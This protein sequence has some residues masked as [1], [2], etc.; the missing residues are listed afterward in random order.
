MAINKDNES[1]KEIGDIS[2]VAQVV[3]SGIMLLIHKFFPKNNFTLVDPPV[4]HEKIPHKKHEIYLTVHEDQY[5]LNSSNALYMTAYSSVFGCVYAISPAFRDEQDSVNHLMEFRILEVEIQDM[6]YN[7]LPDFIE[8]FILFVVTGLETLPEMQKFPEVLKRIKGI[9]DNFPFRR[10]SYRSFLD[11]LWNHG[12]PIKDEI[13]LSDVDYMISQYID[14][15]VFII[16]YPKHLATWT[17]KVKH[18]TDMCAINLIL[19][20]SYGELCEGCE[21]TNDTALLRYKIQCANIDNLQWYLD[22]V[23]EIHK[24]RCGF[25]IGIERLVRWII[26][27]P[28]IK[29]TMFFPRT[30]P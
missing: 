29:D 11:E 10:I 1:F 9:R 14:A 8:R 16:D 2:V 20:G 4:L 13:D 18:D 24:S 19:P 28:H 27:A 23:S 25:G 22:A 26:G 3:R 6:A 7:E 30:S 21:R 5:S 15:P 17:A 12:Y